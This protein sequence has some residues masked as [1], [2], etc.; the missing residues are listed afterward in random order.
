VAAKNSTNNDFSNTCY[1]IIKSRM[2]R[3]LLDEMIEKNIHF[4]GECLAFFDQKHGAQVL[5]E[6]LVIT[7]VGVGHWMSFTNL[8]Q[9]RGHMYNPEIDPNNYFDQFVEINSSNNFIYEK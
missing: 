6:N 1:E 9:P 3:E 5:N 7:S 4:S 2:T 8:D